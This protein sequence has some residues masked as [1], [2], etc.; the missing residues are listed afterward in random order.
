MDTN[1]TAEQLIEINK[2]FSKHK[3]YLSNLNKEFILNDPNKDYSWITLRK[4]YLKN[5]DRNIVYRI[6]SCP[7]N[8]N[9]YAND[10]L[11]FPWG[12]EGIADFGWGCAWRCI[13]TQLS[14][15]LGVPPS[16]KAL[17]DYFGKQSN[18]DKIYKS[19]YVAPFGTS[20]NWADPFLGHLIMKF[21]YIQSK[22]FFV[23]NHI[24]G[25]PK[26]FDV[27]S[28]SQF[29][30]DLIKHFREVGT[31]IMVDDNTYAY[32]IIGVSVRDNLSL[33]IADPH[34][35]PSS[36]KKMGDEAITIVEYDKPVKGL[37][38]IELDYETGKN[39]KGGIIDFNSKPWLTL[40]TFR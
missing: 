26:E 18:I 33:W 38:V 7:S 29:R 27:L 4:R 5:K 19:I 37:Y 15:H 13:Q 3:L 10:I 31:P 17:F 34:I 16:F 1:I 20:S 32:N 2:K 36:H 30:N 8:F 21:F 6:I 11:Y 25:F 9:L 24:N 40:K 28:Y 12:S 23:N 35:G 22:F 14:A 39:L